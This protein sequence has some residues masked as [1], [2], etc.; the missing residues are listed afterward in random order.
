LTCSTEKAW[1]Q[2]VGDSGEGLK[3]TDRDLTR[4]EELRR[5]VI[6]SSLG[7]LGGCCFDSTRGGNT[8]G[9]RTL[10]GRVAR[11]DGTVVGSFAGHRMVGVKGLLEVPVN[12]QADGRLVEDH[13]GQ[14]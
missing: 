8:G 2:L 11:I 10:H 6:L 14:E 7:D 3:R 1:H 13:G 12:D 4:V 9:R 5:E